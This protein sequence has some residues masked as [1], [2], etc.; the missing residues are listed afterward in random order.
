MEALKQR[1][2]LGSYLVRK[3]PTLIPLPPPSYPSLAWTG[4]ELNAQ[5][6]LSIHQTSS[7]DN[8]TI[9]DFNTPSEAI[10]S[11]H[12]RIRF[13]MRQRRI[14]EQMLFSPLTTPSNSSLLNPFNAP[15][16]ATRSA[17]RCTR[18]SPA[19][20]FR[21]SLP[22]QPASWLDVLRGSTN[23]GPTILMR[24][25]W[26][27]VSVTVTHSKDKALMPPSCTISQS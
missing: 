25:R 21:S 20:T 18:A 11:H 17:T 2:L 10:A 7:F 5:P 3:P 26:R 14:K 6:P 22:S 27:W 16:L 9:H 19:S 24:R 4:T 1:C 15:L 23:R 8:D 12:Q 13:L